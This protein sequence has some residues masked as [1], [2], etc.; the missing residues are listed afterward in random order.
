MLDQ[1]IQLLADQYTPAAPGSIP[2]G[3]LA[4]VEGTPMDLRSSLPIGQRI[5]E[6][7]P[8]LLQARGYDHNWILPGGVTAEPRLFARAASPSSG[9]TLEALTTLPGVQ[10]YT[11][12][13]LAGC[14]RGKGGA[15]YGDR[16]GF[17]LETQ[18]FPD[19]PNKAAFPS[20]RLDPGEVWSHTTIY[21]FGVSRA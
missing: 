2:T 6:P 8:Q 3:E 4:S 20:C 5:D 19:S 17:A 9:V 21:R 14:P 1:T 10:F 15:P 7:F 18:F 11:G 12:N 16:W 13:F